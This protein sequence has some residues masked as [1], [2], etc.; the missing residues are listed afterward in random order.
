M[1][2]QREKPCPSKSSSTT[3]TPEAP[4][5]PD[6]SMENTQEER[7]VVVVVVEEEEEEE[8][9]ELEKMIDLKLSCKDSNDMFKPEL[10]LI[11]CLNM[12]STRTSSAN[13]QKPEAEPRV[14]SCTYCRRKFFSSQALGGHQNAHKRERTLAKRGL[15]IWSPVPPHGHSYWHHDQHDR[16][17]S[18]ASLPLHGAYNYNSRAL[19]IQAHSMIHKASNMPSSSGFRSLYGH[20]GWSRLPIDQQPAVGK[21]ATQNHHANPSSSTGLSSSRVGVGRF[22][23][24]RMMMTGSPTDEVIGGYWWAGGGNS[25]LK[26]NQDEM[27]KLDLS[28]KL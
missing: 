26:T 4:P 28:L 14:F 20:G 8:D 7:T 6:T 3:S 15:K 9:G 10:N 25:R 12:D 19:G 18:L 13:P 17:S 5:S 2:P 21:L 24:A 16:Y 22:D 1:E 23:A 27:Q 11:D